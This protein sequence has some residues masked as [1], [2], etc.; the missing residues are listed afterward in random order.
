MI[1]GEE[2][3]IPAPHEPKKFSGRL[4]GG[5]R[6]AG[7]P[8]KGE[9]GHAGGTGGIVPAD[10]F[11]RYPCADGVGCAGGPGVG[12][13]KNQRD[14]GGP[15][16]LRRGLHHGRISIGPGSGEATVEGVPR[17]VGEAVEAVRADG[18]RQP[19]PGGGDSGG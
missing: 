3:E 16:D 17:G 13:E 9:L 15:G 5:S 8:D 19:R 11:H 7:F 10:L 1:S 4:V 18:D 12:G 6:R 14:G 2:R